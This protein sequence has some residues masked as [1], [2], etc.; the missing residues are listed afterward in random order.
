MGA[1]ASVRQT[2][3]QQDF[4]QQVLPTFSYSLTAIC[5]NILAN[6]V[7]SK[8]PRDFFGSLLKAVGILSEYFQK[9][10]PLHHTGTHQYAKVLKQH[11]M[12][13]F[14]LSPNWGFCYSVHCVGVGCPS[15]AGLCTFSYKDVETGGFWV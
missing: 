2:T 5:R 12:N 9:E 8:Y 6:A 10:H 1:E 14:S 15:W 13:G 11:W 3:E 4:L 7:P